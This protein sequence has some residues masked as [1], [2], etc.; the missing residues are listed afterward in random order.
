MKEERKSLRRS[1]FL[2]PGGR[3]AQH[4]VTT[5]RMIGVVFLTTAIAEWVMLAAIPLPAASLILWSSV[6]SFIVGALLLI[7]PKRW[8][9]DE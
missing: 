8:Y 2:P 6:L 4:P 3:R 5:R 1:L 7:V 9:N